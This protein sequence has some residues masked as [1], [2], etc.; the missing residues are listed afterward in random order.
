M[1]RVETGGNK[2]MAA[3]MP[4]IVLVHGV[5]LDGSSWA[6]V[7]RDLGHR[8]YEVHAAQIPLTSFEDDVAAVRRTIDHAGGPV[9]LVGHSYGGAV[10]SAAGNSELVE[11]LVYIAALVPQ[12]GQP[13]GAILAENP[14]AAHVEMKP[15]AEGFIWADAAGFHDAIAHDIHRP[16]LD[17]AIA[18]QKPFAGKIFAAS[19]P[20]PAWQSKPSW[21]LVTTED[22]ILNPITQRALAQKI[23][24]KAH[25]VASSHLPQMAKPHSVIDIVVEAAS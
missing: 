1:E 16:L 10:I 8:G 12:P 2:K 21:Y 15:D 9:I 22:R 4:K 19:I 17:L 14:P 20:N 18:V 7:V 5:W 11:K 23:N 24:A 3:A 13:F 25:E 6:E